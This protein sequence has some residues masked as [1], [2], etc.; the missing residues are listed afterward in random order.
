MLWT[1]ART[2]DGRGTGAA[3]GWDLRHDSR[4]RRVMLFDGNLPGA[5]SLIAVHPEEGLAVAL[6]ANTGKS[7]FLNAE[8]ILNLLELFID[9]APGPRRGESADLSGPY[10]YDVV[11]EGERVHGTLLLY[12]QQGDYRGAL[13]LPNAFFGA[14]V[15]HVPVVQQRGTEIELIAVLGNWLR[16]RLSIPT[17]SGRGRGTWDFGGMHG[18]VTAVNRS[19][20]GTRRAGPRRR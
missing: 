4:G 9:P 7:I 1:E 5:R 12:R 19:V 13:T 10:E 16:M 8:E 6:I 20:P 2:R 17:D 11:F 3:M 18:E 15:F 14:Q